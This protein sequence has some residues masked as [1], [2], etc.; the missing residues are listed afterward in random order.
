MKYLSPE[1]LDWV[2]QKC[3]RGDKGS[4]DKIVEQFVDLVFTI[5]K[6]CGLNTD[7][8]HDVVQSSFIALYGARESIVSSQVLLRWLTVTAKRE[9]VHL[10]QK[11]K[12]QGASLD[13]D[14][15]ISELVADDAEGV[16]EILEQ[17]ERGLQI[18]VALS[19]LDDKCRRLLSILF[20]SPEVPYTDIASQLKIAIGSIGPSR[21]RCLERLRGHAAKLGLFS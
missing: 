10:S 5:A 13:D 12:R 21:A 14:K 20:F 2:W 4:W 17:A 8:A 1:E 9:A 3:V 6:R 11:K 15:G 19:K 16:D 7:E 18:R